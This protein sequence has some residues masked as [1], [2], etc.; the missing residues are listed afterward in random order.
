[1]HVMVWMDSIGMA[2]LVSTFILNK[3]AGDV[4]LSITDDALKHLDV[5]NPVDRVKIL[6]KVKALAGLCVHCVEC[7]SRH[8]ILLLPC[9]LI[10]V[11]D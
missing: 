2:A 5:T 8:G 6:A 11:L 3:I 10:G 1:M 9:N 7:R 4:L